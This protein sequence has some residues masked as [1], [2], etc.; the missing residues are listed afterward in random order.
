MITPTAITTEQVSDTSKAR[1]VLELL[2]GLVDAIGR[3]GTFR[4]PGGSLYVA[5]ASFGCT[6]ERFNQ[7]MQIL[8]ASGRIEKRGDCY[9]A[10]VKKGAAK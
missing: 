5:L 1:A 9:F 7:L 8:I 4:T 3:S 10:T 6:L 2:D